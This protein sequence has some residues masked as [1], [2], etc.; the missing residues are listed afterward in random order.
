MFE[1]WA[2]ALAG[3][4][5]IFAVLFLFA[6]A[7]GIF[8]PVPSESLVIA[9]AAMAI[10]T[11]RPNLWLVLLVA[12]L[13]AFTGDQLAYQLGTR[14]HRLRLLRSARGRSAIARAEGT[15]AARGASVIIAARYVPVGRVAVNMTAGA[16]RYPRRRFVGLAAVAAVTWSVYV[17]LIGIGAGAWLGGNM[18]V[19]VGVGIL[20]GIAL[21][22]VVD[23]AMRRPNPP[24]DAAPGEPAP[25]M[26]VVGHTA[27]VD[28]VTGRSRSDRAA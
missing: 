15:L 26:A 6:A 11:G 20:G 2:S 23:R 14:A 9:L 3:S 21:G 24:S 28:S 22:V 27:P 17:A 19:A 7:D 12:S 25:V 5:W 18:P 13:G 1:A 8:P 4:P 16:V 10:S